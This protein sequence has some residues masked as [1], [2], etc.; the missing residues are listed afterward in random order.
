MREQEAIFI[1]L[2][3]V[4]LGGLLFLSVDV[5]DTLNTP[6]TFAQP[7]RQG[8]VFSP[9]PQPVKTPERQEIFLA[10]L[11]EGEIVG[12][13]D[14]FAFAR[15]PVP[16]E[17]VALPKEN[18]QVP[19]E[20]PKGTEPGEVRPEE[21]LPSIV[22]KGVVASSTKRVVVVEVDGKIYFL[23]PEKPLSGELKLVKVDKRQVILAYQGR[24]F[25]FSL[26]E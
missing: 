1:V 9:P 18:V 22:V 4:A 14:V 15:A 2:L 3:A 19:K 13:R 7:S 8:P 25:T 23:T 16:Q 26:E 11:Q 6:Q 21:A 20:T 5:I 10:P 17:I 24:E 12:L